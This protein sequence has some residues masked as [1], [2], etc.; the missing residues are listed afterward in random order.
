MCIY[1]M[2]KKKNHSIHDHHHHGETSTSKQIQLRPHKVKQCS[3][4]LPYGR[5]NFGIAKSKRKKFLV[6]SLHR[7]HS[8]LHWSALDNYLCTYW[9][10]L[11][12]NEMFVMLFHIGWRRSAQNV[13][14]CWISLF[15]RVIWFKI[16]N[17]FFFV[18]II[19]SSS[20]SKSCFKTVEN[21][22]E[23]AQVER[24]EILTCTLK[25]KRKHI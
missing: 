9:F 25:N 15:S 20:T 19:S 12:I 3:A 22:L 7:E 21:W 11:M 2:L 23:R 5:R 4:C 14:R 24:N 8:K 13:H 16:S 1:L 6:S 17:E 10:C 18:F